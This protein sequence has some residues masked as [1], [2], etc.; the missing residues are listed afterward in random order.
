MDY[1]ES[2]NKFIDDM[3]YLKNDEVE[4]IVFY[5]SYHTGTNNE[6]SDIDLMILFDDDSDINQVK[7][8]KKV[9]GITVEY[10]ERTIS[11]VY[12]RANSDYMKCEDSLLS[13]IGYGEIIFDRNGKVQ[14]L[15]DYV[16][17]KYSRP[18]PTYTKHEAL[19]QILSVKRAVDA[20]EELRIQNDPYFENYFFITVERIRLFYHR[21]NGLSNLPQTKVCK[22]YTNE[23]LREVQHKRIPEQKFIDLYF[24][25]IE[26]GIS[27]EEKI[28]RINE[29]LNYSIRKY[30]I[31]FDDVRIDLGKKRY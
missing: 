6:F 23:R 14:D 29:L 31:N 9:K 15:V 12:E 7:G 2:L 10:F 18:L 20:C 8:Y 24:R 19:Y 16:K 25:A 4:G 13:I 11:K 21:L 30:D 22:L 17:E 3:N 26:Y 5:G 28:A 1:R 27:K